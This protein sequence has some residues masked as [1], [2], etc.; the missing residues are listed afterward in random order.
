M[1]DRV[2]DLSVKYLEAIKQRLYIEKND[3]QQPVFFRSRINKFSLDRLKS[4]INDLYRSSILGNALTDTAAFTKEKGLI[5]TV[6]YGI[7]EDF[8]RLIKMGFL[9]GDRVVIWDL[10][11]TRILSEIS[12]N[13]KYFDL[14]GSIACNLILL[15]ELVKKGAI[16]IL[17][18]PITWNEQTQ[19]VIKKVNE[20][21][22]SD[23]NFALLSVLSTIEDFTLHPYTYFDKAVPRFPSIDG[24]YY[25]K[26]Q[27]QL[28]NSLSK[29]FDDNNFV[30]L[31]GISTDSFYS[32]LHKNQ[33]FNTELRKLFN[34]GINQSNEQNDKKFQQI[35]SDIEKMKNIRNRSLVSYALSKQSAIV[36]LISSVST[37]IYAGISQKNPEFF[38]A[39]SAL[40]GPLLTIVEKYLSKPAKPVL[41]NVFNKLEKEYEKESIQN[42][43]TNSKFGSSK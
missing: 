8:Q 16:V 13:Y 37:M 28:H 6:G 10:L 27:F 25:N 33:D 20:K 21:D 26:Q 41:I 40:S 31:D 38:L 3:L 30:F 17:P 43:L 5:Q 29:L 2:T 22:L 9:L 1:K 32:V 18:P 39:M 12:D 7:V 23:T 42:Y 24:D 4:D 35:T 34:P 15:E 36:S 14:V 19:K 11:F